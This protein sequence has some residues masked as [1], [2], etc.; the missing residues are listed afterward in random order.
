LVKIESLPLNRV[1]S[2]GEELLDFNSI[3]DLETWLS[4]N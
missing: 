1:E 4:Q 2:L 3:E